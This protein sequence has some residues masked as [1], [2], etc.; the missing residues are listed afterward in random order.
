MSKYVLGLD[1]GVGSVGWSIVDKESGTIIDKGVRLFSE[2]N[3]EENVKRRDFRHTRR[4]LRRKEFRLYRTRRLLLNMGIIDSIDFRPLDNPYELRVKGLTKKLSKDELATAILHLMKRN[5][6]RY[7]IADEED[8]GKKRIKEDY[9]C[10]H[11]LNELNEFGKVRGTNNKYHFSLYLKEFKKLL[12]VQGVSDEYK[13]KLLTIFETR[14]HYS[15]GPG[16]PNS[17]T[18]YG[19]Y[20]SF[21][22]DPINLIDKMRG[23]CSIY[24]EEL[25]APRICPSAELYNFLN[26][27]NNLRV[28]DNY[29]SIEN[30]RDI[31]ETYILGK[32]KITVKQLCDF[33]GTS[34]RNVDGF[35][36]NTSGKAIITEFKSL[37]KVKDACKKN[38]LEEFPLDSFEDFYLLDEVF[39]VLTKTKILEEREKDLKKIK[40]DKLNPYISAFSRITGVS[41]YHSLSIK[42]LRTLIDEMFETHK[43]A[44]QI[45]VTLE[46]PIEDSKQLKLLD[47]VIMSPVV[48]KSV[49][50]AFKII[51]A[52]NKKYGELESVIIE[53][54]R[55]K[56]SKDEADRIKKSQAARREEKERVL[57]IIGKYIPEPNGRTVDLV[58]LYLQQDCKSIYSGKDIDL[59]DLLF[60]Q[61]KFEID[62]IIPY[63]I[64]F[65]DSRNNKVLVYKEENQFKGNKTPHYAFLENPEGW[66]S[67]EE[68]EIFVRQSASA[69]RISDRKK[70]N[71]LFKKNIK[72]DD[73]KEEFVNRNLNDTSYI[74]REVMTTLKSYYSHNNIHTK[75]FVINGATTNLVR[76]LAGLHKDRN[77][78]CHHAVDA[79]I[80]ASFTRSQYIEASLLNKLYDEETGEVF[81]DADKRKIFGP[82]VESVSEQ[83]QSLD[84]ILDYKFSYKIDSKPNRSISDQT[85]YG[86]RYIDGELYAVKKYKNIY[87]AEGEKV[88]E[89]LRTE[90]NISKLLMFNED[91]KTLAYLKKIVDSYPNEKN[92]FQAFYKEHGEYIKKVSKKGKNS[93]NIVSIRYI[94]DKINS[95][96][97]LSNRYA[98]PNKN[99]GY[100]VKLQLSPYR[101]DLYVNEE[102]T[103]KFVTVR[104]AN[105]SN[106]KNKYFIDEKWYKKELEKKSISPNYKFVNTFY[107]GDLILLRYA[108]GTEIFEVFKTVNNDLNNKIENSYFGKETTKNVDGEEKKFQNMISIGKKVTMVQKYSTDILGNRFLVSGERLKMEW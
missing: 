21:G 91:V 84:P 76:K 100:P 83:L 88:A 70:D 1:L 29:I 37:A 14:R 101:M 107:R 98:T 96:L 28:N 35:R 8:D 26:D 60:N 65:D 3:P 55:S 92:P 39:E 24:P 59:S 79:C 68:F 33:L 87:G 63:S 90:K 72:A 12:E 32:G 18:K 34:D 43:N 104:Y 31:F 52:I 49:N 27:L 6:F 82:I 2:S 73:V 38:G 85:L 47:G 64:S 74:T 53:M 5:G 58:L 44:Q 89:C 42:A 54:T 20:L 23:H 57:E 71:L 10:Q 51:K 9:L 67:E 108:D 19:C 69:G 41:E 99:K 103:Y 61:E 106:K 16:G 45:I 50:Q 56:N 97:D 95:S 17:P 40:S 15:Q 80:A 94:E 11:Q 86:T 62:H 105:V 36:V 13:E 93:P 25:R 77:Y 81:I 102:G 22:A 7:E 78:Y 46:K 48:Y 75:V 66:W 30:K 4:L